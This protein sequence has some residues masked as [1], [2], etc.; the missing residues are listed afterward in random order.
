LP[1]SFR[2]LGFSSAEAVSR[3][4][5]THAVYLGHAQWDRIDPPVCP[6]PRGHR[7]AYL[8]H[9]VNALT[10]SPTMSFRISIR[11]HPAASRTRVGG[12]RGGT[13]L[14]SV[15]APADDGK[16][17]EATRRALAEAFDLRPRQVAIIR[18]H[19]SRD[20]VVELDLDSAEAQPILTA[21][22]GV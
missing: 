8:D 2:E 16:A 6:D 17:N 20:K 15:T 14:V 13:L 3:A 21:L 22:L 11:V 10:G 4:K 1:N 9:V 5:L 19:H 18:G 12:H 7:R